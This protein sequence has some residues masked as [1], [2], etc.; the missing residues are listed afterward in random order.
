MKVFTLVALLSLVAVGCR[1]GDTMPRQFDTNTVL[2]ISVLKSGEV[3]AEG[4]KVSMQEL[5]ALIATNALKNGIVWYYREA[6]QEEPPT[7]ALE[8]INLVVKH[9][10]PVRLSSRADFSDTVDK[11]GR[12]VRQGQ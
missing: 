8:V 7:Q 6:G 4:G 3:L 12:P 2:K 11:S 9:R 5:D 1:K 10:R